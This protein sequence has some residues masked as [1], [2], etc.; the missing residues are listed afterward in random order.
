MLQVDCVNWFRANYKTPR[1]MILVRGNGHFFGPNGPRYGKKLKDAGA[2]AGECDLSSPGHLLKKDKIGLE[3]E[4]K[5]HPDR[6]SVTQRAH[7]ECLRELGYAVHVC[8][9]L[10]EFQDAVIEYHGSP[11]D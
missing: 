7:H 3:V 9:T 2:V 6:P 11:P 10:R 8:Y 5:V 4:L 1:Y